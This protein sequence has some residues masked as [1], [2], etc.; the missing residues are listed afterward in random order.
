MSETDDQTP[1]RPPTIELSATEIGGSA[2]K[3]AASDADAGTTGA[4]ERVAA[5]PNAPGSAAPGGRF[6]SH[7]ASA[8]IGAAVMAGAAA[9]LW[10]TG[11]IPLRETVP[12]GTAASDTSASAPPSHPTPNPTPPE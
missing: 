5:G 3:A 12:L 1:R 11:V 7:I 2:D 8:L 10:F 9:A 6:A 4:S